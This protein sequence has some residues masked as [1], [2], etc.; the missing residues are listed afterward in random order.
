MW[1]SMIAAAIHAAGPSRGTWRGD[2]RSSARSQLAVPVDKPGGDVNIAITTIAVKAAERQLDPPL[3]VAA[4]APAGHTGE[5]HQ[6]RS[7]EAA[8]D[9]LR[10]LG[11]D[12][13]SLL[14]AGG[15]HRAK[16]R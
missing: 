3:G 5:Q 10:G 6:K 4:G 13:V 14:T 16:R 7:A 9:G 15:D 12:R 1:T 11:L 8:G 2:R